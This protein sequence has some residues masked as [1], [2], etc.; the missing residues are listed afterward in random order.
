MSDRFGS[1]VHWRRSPQTLAAAAAAAAA[2]P[3]TIGMLPPAPCSQAICLRQLFSTMAA[4]AACQQRQLGAT[5]GR[6]AA[7]AP[8]L[9]P[10][11]RRQQ[12]RCGSA[13]RA[14]ADPNELLQL[15]SSTAGS[16]QTV[17]ADLAAALPAGVAEPVVAAASTLATG[18]PCVHR[19]CAAQC[20][21][22]VL[23]SAPGQTAWAT[24]RFW[25]CF[26]L[27]AWEGLGSCAASNSLMFVSIAGNAT[28]LRRRGRRGGAAADGRWHGPPGRH[29]LRLFHPPLTL[30]WCGR[31]ACSALLRPAFGPSDACVVAE[32]SRTP[33]CGTP[34]N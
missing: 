28:C 14:V 3:F 13:V 6:Q 27:V 20:S 9:P 19:G 33:L 30:H 23:R 15:A 17:A 21:S 2:C 7:T 26:Q 22:T 24:W 4:S 25:A 8:L 11:R 10:R 32:L 5:L 29:L 16:L 31:I 18:G 12:R 1:R 34:V